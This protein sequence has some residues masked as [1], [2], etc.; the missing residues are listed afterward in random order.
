MNTSMKTASDKSDK[1]HYARCISQLK[2]WGA[3]LDG[4]RCIDVIDIR[5]DDWSAP[6]SECELCGC[7]N[8]RYEHVMEHD[9][10]FEEVTVGCIC[11]G[12]ME[13]NILKAQERERLMRNRSERR[14]HFLDR[15]WKH[16]RPNVWR[17]R[18]RK[19]DLSIWKFD[20]GYVVYADRKMIR[21]YKDKPIRDFYSAVYAAF[22]LADPVEEIL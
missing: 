2:K 11:A 4:W 20:S 5:E 8:V 9:L 3:P 17:R 1:I 6:L 18:Y 15:P 7:A 19:Q 22:N 13:G 14:R 16:D 10:Y 21:T 12:I